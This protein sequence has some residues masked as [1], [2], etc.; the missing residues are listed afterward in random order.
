MEGWDRIFIENVLAE[1]KLIYGESSYED[2]LFKRLELEPFQAISFNLKGIKQKEKMRL[3]RILYGYDTTKKH[4]KKIYNYNKKGLVEKLNGMRLG[5]G[6][7]L[8]PESEVLKVEK[9]LNKFGIHF[10]KRRVWMQKV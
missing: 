4:A 1:G 2:I 6:A 5:R 7:F 10:S 8:I 9:K 3:K